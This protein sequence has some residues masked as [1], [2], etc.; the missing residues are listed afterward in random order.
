MSRLE[1]VRERRLPKTLVDYDERYDTM[2]NLCYPKT[3]ES[4]TKHVSG[5]WRTAMMDQYSAL[6]DNK[7][8]EL[9]DIFAFAC[10]S[11]TVSL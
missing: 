2:L 9:K 7:T 10:N 3:E 1:E 4:S 8:C 5:Q 6:M 11:L